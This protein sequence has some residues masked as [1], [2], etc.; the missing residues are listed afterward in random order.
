MRQLCDMAL[1]LVSA[2]AWRA[3]KGERLA[4]AHFQGGILLPKKLFRPRPMREEGEPRGE[5]S[6]CS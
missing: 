6:L 3:T 5:G 1:A 2:V 4:A